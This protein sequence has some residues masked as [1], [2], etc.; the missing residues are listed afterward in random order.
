MSIELSVYFQY[1]ISRL[2]RLWG[3]FKTSKPHFDSQNDPTSIG[4]L[5]PAQVD[6][7]LALLAQKGC[8]WLVL[9]GN[10][11]NL[12]WIWTCFSD[13]QVLNRFPCC[14]ASPTYEEG[15]WVSK[16]QMDGWMF[17][18]FL[19]G[20]GALIRSYAESLFATSP[21][22][23]CSNP[24]HFAAIRPTSSSQQSSSSADL[25]SCGGEGCGLCRCEYGSP[26]VQPQKGGRA[27]KLRFLVLFP[28][29]FLDVFCPR[30]CHHLSADAETAKLWPVPRVSFNDS[31]YSSLTSE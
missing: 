30:W 9:E 14:F 18:C 22:L 2:G 21:N 20:H 28:S 6:A 8:L 31:I 5:S 19:P 25:R 29:R 17:I 11:W 24:W 12:G 26:E 1:W 13:T 3:Q 23:G 27:T 10:W 7:W 15:C 16:R 4:P